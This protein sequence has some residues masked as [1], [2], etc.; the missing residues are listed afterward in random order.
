MKTVIQDKMRRGTIVFELLSQQVSVDINVEIKGF[1][2][3]DK[4]IRLM[5]DRKELTRAIGA[6][7]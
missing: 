4:K 5:L 2:L 1:D 7:K 3:G 6:M